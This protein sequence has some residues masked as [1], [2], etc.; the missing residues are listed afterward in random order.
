M[1]FSQ[2]SVSITMLQYPRFKFV[3]GEVYGRNWQEK[4]SADKSLFTKA[5][6]LGCKF[7]NSLNHEY[8]IPSNLDGIIIRPK[9][10]FAQLSG[11]Y[12]ETSTVPI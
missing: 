8:L 6:L 1:F 5:N 9:L 11:G 2:F 10:D 12:R 7:S 3:G 4:T